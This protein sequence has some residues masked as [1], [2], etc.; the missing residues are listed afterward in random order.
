MRNKKGSAVAIG[1]FDGFHLGHQKLVGT[2]KMIAHKN[3]LIS[4]VLTFSPNPRVYFNK[5]LNLINSDEQK[6]EILVKLDVDN[7]T[8]LNFDDIMDM[9]GEEFVKDIL[10]KKFNVKFIVMGENFKFGKNREGDVEFLKKMGEKLGF[11]F[12]IVSPILLDGTR[13]SSSLIREK[14]DHAEIEESNQMMGRFYYID[15]IIEEGDMLGRKLGFPTINIE[16]ENEI[17][18]EGVFKTRVE[19]DNHAYDSITYIGYRPTFSGRDKK[20]ESHIFKFTK[21]VYGKRVRLYFEKKLRGEMKF[22]SKTNLIDQVKKDIQSL[23]V[24]KGIFF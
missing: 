14:L 7:V 6:K 19:I 20:V 13:V 22:D 15:G 4:I 24:D 21:N 10:I 23:K 9:S 11:E 8:L 5:D 12:F 18:P 1:N 16:T 3:N 2:L 17:L